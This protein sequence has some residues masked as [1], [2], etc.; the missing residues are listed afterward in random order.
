MTAATFQPGNS[1]MRNAFMSAVFAVL[2]A[3]VFGAPALAALS[4][5]AAAPDFTLPATLGG[6]RFDFSLAEALKK[7]PVVLYFYP[8]AFT[9]G[10]TF[11][12]HQFADAMDTFTAAG[13]SVIG[14][15]RDDLPKLDK[16]SVAE[17]NN[18]F[19]VASDASGRMVAAYDAA[20]ANNPDLANRVSYV[21]APDG[22][23]IFAYSDMDA[24]HHVEKTLAAV[25]AWRDSH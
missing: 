6:Q 15:S 1:I 5:G 7:G 23:V 12:A 17:C 9:R 25:K 18:K 22:K 16:F 10:C 20:L 24:A 2:S 14:V 3:F 21:I 11:E 19:P 4:V 13:A 8:A